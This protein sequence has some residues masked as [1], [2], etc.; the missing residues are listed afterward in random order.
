MRKKVY[1][2]NE[3]NESG[4]TTGGN[5]SDP[6]LLAKLSAIQKRKIDLKKIYD[7]NI[8]LLDK[9]IQEI[10]VQQAKLLKQKQNQNG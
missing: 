1:R 5:I 7:N 3:E 10:Y 9:Q 4:E 8:N 2:L 6:D